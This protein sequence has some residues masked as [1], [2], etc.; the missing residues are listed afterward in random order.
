[1]ILEGFPKKVCEVMWSVI[2][3]VYHD[4]YFGLFKF[5]ATSSINLTRSFWNIGHP[6]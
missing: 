3:V 1:M 5:L 4:F 6:L 2:L